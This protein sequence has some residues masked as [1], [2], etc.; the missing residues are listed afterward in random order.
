[1]S[2]HTDAY[3]KKEQIGTLFVWAP[4][5]GFMGGVQPKNHTCLYIPPGLR[6]RF[7]VRTALFVFLSFFRA[8]WR[9]LTRGGVSP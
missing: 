2:M 3:L 6:F 4:E 5:G 1:M 8:I 7:P 9:S